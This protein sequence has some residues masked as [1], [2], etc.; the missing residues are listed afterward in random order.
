[1]AVYKRAYR[2]YTGPITA[3]RWRFLVLTRYSLSQL[4]SSRAFSWFMMVT[5]LPVILSA[6][7]VYVTNS[8]TAQLVLRMGNQSLLS[9]DGTFFSKILIA[10]AWMALFLTCWAGPLLV[11]SD[12]SNSALPLYLSRPLNRA[13]YVTGK[14][15]VLVLILS[16]VTWIPV[17]L[18]F[19]LQSSLAGGSW[20]WQHLS[21]VAAIL[22]GSFVWIAVLTLMSLATSAWVKWRIVATAVTFGLFVLPPGFGEA[23]NGV[24][25]TSWGRVLNLPYLLEMILT[26][27]LGAP[28][29]SHGPFSDQPL[30]QFAAWVVLVGVC[31]ASLALLNKRL[32]ACEVVRG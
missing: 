32:R 26:H 24:M 1:M 12:L 25:R 13:E 10:Q 14:A 5:L 3:E 19:A 27:M 7:Y 16:C 4:F 2:S 30:P 28:M 20:A 15:A 11:A 22:A 18:I 17:L 29:Q 6:A 8:V 21:F 31:F 23:I 9:V